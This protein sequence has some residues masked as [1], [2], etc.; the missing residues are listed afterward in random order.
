MEAKKLIAVIFLLVPALSFASG[1]TGSISTAG[2]GS[3]SISI[4][5]GG[6]G[7]I[8][9]STD[10]SYDAPTGFSIVATSQTISTATW[11]AVLVLDATSYTLQY[12]DNSDFSSITA[13]SDTL[14]TTARVSGLTANTQYYA[15]VRENPGYLFSVTASTLTPAIPTPQIDIVQS[16]GAATGGGTSVDL[17]FASNGTDGTTMVIA[18][19]S[20][21]AGPRPFDTPTGFTMA[22]SAAS[23][24]FS[25]YYYSKKNHSVGVASAT[26]T[27]AGGLSGAI[28]ASMFE[29]TNMADTPSAGN[30]FGTGTGTSASVA[31]SITGTGCIV[32]GM[33]SHDSAADP[34]LT[35]ANGFTMRHSVTESGALIAEATVDYGDGANV[36]TGSYTPT[37]TIG[38]SANWGVLGQGFCQ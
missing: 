15:R 19:M 31:T 23:G 5:G 4:A 27:I 13:S 35:A 21:A 12:D 26:L 34:S 18:A 11:N 38:T 36:N 10:A 24:N 6:S 16:T 14:N 37:V 33:A 9:T 3:G 32:M 1:R 20:N 29:Y 22:S 28:T 17:Q 7:S 30:A 2:G 25:L 8:G